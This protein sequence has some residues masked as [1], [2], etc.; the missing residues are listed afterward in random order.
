LDLPSTAEN[1]N[2]LQFDSD[3]DENIYNIELDEEENCI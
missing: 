2:D 1:K 3:D